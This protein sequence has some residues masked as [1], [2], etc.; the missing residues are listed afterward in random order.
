MGHDTIKVGNFRKNIN[1]PFEYF[2]IPT[3]L[4]PYMENDLC[5]TQFHK[6]NIEL[7]TYKLLN[8]P[9]R[10][11][12]QTAPLLVNGIVQNLTIMENLINLS[13][14]K[15]L[16]EP[17][18]Y[19]KLGDDS[20]DPEAISGGTNMYKFNNTGSELSSSAI[21]LN[22]TFSENSITPDLEQ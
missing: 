15:M 10:K 4:Y 17:A 16:I 13:V 6:S 18:K 2:L 14:N 9:S 5:I 22:I 19:K 1:H 11:F 8:E 21:D 3:Q 20:V 7:C 12:I